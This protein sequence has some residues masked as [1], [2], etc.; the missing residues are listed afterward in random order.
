MEQRGKEV[1]GLR[2]PAG[3]ELVEG[4]E[5]MPEGASGAPEVSPGLRPLRPHHMQ[6]RPVCRS[7]GIASPVP[8]AENVQALRQNTSRK[9]LLRSAW[10][11]SAVDTGL[12]LQA[13]L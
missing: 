6:P 2:K 5:R 12:S 13:K 7:P 1:P 11:L 3:A 8:A 4:F 10:A 9:E